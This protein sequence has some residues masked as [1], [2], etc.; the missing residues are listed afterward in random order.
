MIS[1]SVFYLLPKL[2]LCHVQSRSH[3]K[4]R[5]GR[6]SSG[7][8]AQSSAVASCTF[9]HCPDDVLERYT[10]YSSYIKVLVPDFSYV[11]L[12]LL[13]IQV[14]SASN[15]LERPFCSQVDL[16]PAAFISIV[17]CV[18]VSWDTWFCAHYVLRR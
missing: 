6:V 13:F 4:G 7:L 14:V 3:W 17:Q 5:E 2:F 10:S 16:L 15:I 9:H 1:L 18:K 8:R 11:R 12:V